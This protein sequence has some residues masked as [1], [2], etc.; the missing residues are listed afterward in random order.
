[1]RSSRRFCNRVQPLSDFGFETPE[2]A[3]VRLYPCEETLYNDLTP[4][5]LHGHHA[6]IRAGRVRSYA[7]WHN[8]MPQAR[9]WD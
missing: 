1:M 3:S 8:L 9:G 6:K 4:V 5:S 2:M 7:M